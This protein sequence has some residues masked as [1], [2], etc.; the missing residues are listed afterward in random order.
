MWFVVSIYYDKTASGLVL[1]AGKPIFNEIYK[2]FTYMVP[3]KFFVYPQPTDQ[4]GGITAALFLFH[5]SFS[6][7][8]V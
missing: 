6:S 5:F 1:I 2:F 4:H 3:L 7:N 8:F